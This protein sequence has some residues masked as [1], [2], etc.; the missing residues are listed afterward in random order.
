M[1]APAMESPACVV[2]ILR[3][4]SLPDGDAAAAIWFTNFLRTG[5][6]HRLPWAPTIELAVF[7]G[8]VQTTKE[9]RD[10][11]KES[12]QQETVVGAEDRSRLPISHGFS[13]ADLRAGCRSNAHR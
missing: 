5:G 3:T 11:D 7:R 1:P 8:S 9:N 4:G 10:E 2:F 12:V 6:G 13:R